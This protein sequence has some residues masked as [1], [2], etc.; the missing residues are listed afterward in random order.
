ML[1]KCLVLEDGMVFWFKVLG[2]RE[3]VE[4]KTCILSGRGG[5]DGSDKSALIK[6][7]LRMC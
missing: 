3:H 1:E 4:K 7:M 6:K 2:L 5:G